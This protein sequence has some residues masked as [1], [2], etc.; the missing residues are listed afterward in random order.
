MSIIGMVLGAASLLLIVLTLV[1]VT[2]LTI[3]FIVL[4]IIVF[5]KV[6]LKIWQNA[7]LSC[8]SSKKP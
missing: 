3:S 4:G 2:R 1:D 5:I 8:E 7:V 6:G